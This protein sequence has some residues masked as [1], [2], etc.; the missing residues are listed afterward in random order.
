MTILVDSSGRLFTKGKCTIKDLLVNREVWGWV[1]K[2]EIVFILT[3]FKLFEYVTCCK[4]S[5]SNE[6]HMKTNSNDLHF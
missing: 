6:K 5:S 2:N 4:P 1:A 3:P